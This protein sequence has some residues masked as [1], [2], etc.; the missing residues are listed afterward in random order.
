VA[1]L[2][3]CTRG[4][5][6]AA[7]TEYDEW[8][9]TLL[10]TSLR[11]PEGYAPPDLVSTS[12]AGLSGGYLVRSIVITDLSALR[13]AAAAAGVPIDVE[14]AYRSYQAQEE[15]LT[16]KTAEEGE[17]EAL[18]RTAR[19]GHSEH[20]LGTAIDL[21]T[22]G[23]EDVPLDWD[24]TPTGRWA[25]DNSW[26]YGFVLSYPRQ[27]EDVTCYGFEPWHFRYF[28]RDIAALVHRSGLTVREYLWQQRYATPQPSAPSPA[29]PGAVASTTA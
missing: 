15:L 21:K 14:A 19:P 13:Q 26:K 11:L 10:D 17:D 5:E 12:G 6:P 4:D 20:Q 23:Q 28:G 25:L 18:K 29:A 16:Q 8:E 24:T 27:R 9:V 1:G 22:E 3:P 7:D 2:P